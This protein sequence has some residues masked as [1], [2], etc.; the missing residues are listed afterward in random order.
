MIKNDI[1]YDIEVIMIETFKTID[2]FSNC[3]TWK[4][5]MKYDCIFDK[6]Y[7]KFLLD[8]IKFLDG[9][10]NDEDL[11]QLLKKIRI[12][13]RKGLKNYYNSKTLEEKYANY[14]EIEKYFG[15]IESI[16]ELSNYSDYIIQKIKKTYKEKSLDILALI[17]KSNPS[18]LTNFNYL[19]INVDK[20]ILNNRYV[21]CYLVLKKW[22]DKQYLFFNKYLLDVDKLENE[23]K[24]FLQKNFINKNYKLRV[25]HLLYKLTNFNVLNMDLL[26]VIYMSGIKNE[27]KDIIGGKGYGL[28]ILKFYGANIPATFFV[29]FWANIDKLKFSNGRYAI[30]SSCNIEDGNENSFAGIFESYLNVNNNDIINKIEKIREC[31]NSNKARSYIEAK[32][33]SDNLKMCVIVQKMINSKYS[34]VWIGNKINSGIYEWIKGL[35]ENLVS[36]NLTPNT[37]ICSSKKQTGNKIQ[38]KD[39]AGE[40]INL[41]KRL[42]TICDFEWT[43]NK[44]NKLYFLQYRPVTTLVRIGSS[45]Y[46]RKS[47]GLSVSNGKAIGKLCF[48]KKNV[49][50]ANGEIILTYFTDPKWVPAMKK[51]SGIITVVGGYLCHTAIIAR[52]L[53][54]PCITNIG[55]DNLCKIQEYEYV[56][57]NANEGI[58]KNLFDTKI[59]IP[60]NIYLR[61]NNDKTEIWNSKTAKLYG[62]D[63]ESSEL[64]KQIETGNI[65]IFQNFTYNKFNK[66]KKFYDLGI[67][68]IL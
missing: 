28:V 50:I 34:G 9:D 62:I 20:R 30:R 16:T 59:L 35:G 29:P 10:P 33:I 38:S 18:K 11:D 45:K 41:Q 7:E 48:L 36:G 23:Y 15:L 13:A 54:K 42:S 19:N 26:Y 21:K 63:R 2:K 46:K 5:R 43:I 27:L 6:K 8:T 39:L 32:N 66:L 57:L 40:F 52:E 4:T 47:L 3:D 56:Y 67:I 25:L 1:I 37:V 14:V 68:D 51:S 31:V 55:L 22:Q 12:K 60:D 61:K 49:D 17:D 24:A 58:I 44:N 53:S 64:L 65:D